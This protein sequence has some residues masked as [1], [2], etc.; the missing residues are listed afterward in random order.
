MLIF[1]VF[2]NFFSTHHNSNDNWLDNPR[3]STQV[4][5]SESS[6]NGRGLNCWRANLIMSLRFSGLVTWSGWPYNSVAPLMSV[7]KWEVVEYSPHL[8]I[9]EQ[10]TVKTRK[11]TLETVDD[12]KYWRWCSFSLIGSGYRK[13][14]SF[15]VE[16]MRLSANEHMSLHNTKGN[17]EQR[18][19]MREINA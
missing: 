6:L 3:P 18:I 15:A 12:D 13:W 2:L 9:I 14:N 5:R 8:Q 17:V 19:E 10:Q 4:I 16:S 11:I 1:F 7:Y